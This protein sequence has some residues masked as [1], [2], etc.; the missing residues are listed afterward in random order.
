MASSS[1][2]GFPGHLLRVGGP[3]T[4]GDARAGM[5]DVEVMFRFMCRLHIAF[6]AKTLSFISNSQ[7]TI[8]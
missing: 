2:A 7:R 1:Q 6:W 8:F 3:S 4:R 5:A